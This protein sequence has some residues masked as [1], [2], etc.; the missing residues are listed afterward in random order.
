MKASELLT[1]D[2][3]SELRKLAAGNLEGPWQVPT[4]L[5]RRALA[6]GARTVEVS[7]SRGRVVIH[8]DGRPLS[9]ER[10]HH[11]AVLLDETQPS[12]VRHEA[13]LALEA[14]PELLSIAAA[15]ARRVVVHS[16]DAGTTVTLL[17]ARIDR[18]A[19][20]RW[21]RSCARFAPARVVVDGE[22]VRPGFEGAWAE[23]SLDA[24][25]DGRLAVT[26]DEGAHLWLLGAGIVSSH[27]TL[28]DTPAFEA[29]IELPRG[30]PSA[31]REAIQPHLG[32]LVD[33]AVR[34][35]LEIAG[36]SSLDPRKQRS[37]RAR[38][39]VAARRGWL[40]DEIFETPLLPAMDA[41]GV[42]HRLRL[43]Q[44]AARRTV[45]CLDTGDD[46]ADFLL[47]REPV[48]QVDAEERGRLA[49]LLSARFQ[50]VV[51][52]RGRLGLAAA[53]RRAALRLRDLAGGLAARLRHPRA[54]RVLPEGRLSAD[55]RAFLAALRRTLAPGAARVEIGAGSGPPRRSRDTWILS[56]DH[57]DVRR[58]VRLVA[59]DPSFAYLAAL[60]LCEDAVPL[61][62]ARD[63]WRDTFMQGSR[64]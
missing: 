10:R 24:P 47:P 57:A 17:G 55:E 22:L 43:S 46:P 31:L 18:E 8:D 50:P 3:D 54:G 1:I 39:F 21:L 48:V 53:L 64:P 15:H 41:Q 45:P 5:V 34:L 42:R 44:L 9:S 29:A 27:L 16:D 62:A 37:V 14:E 12:G 51:R 63:R 26:D 38:L 20:R 25:L 35:L 32:V 4:E 7:L 59:R 23:R 36:R 33:G 52:R 13:L 28:P 61:P 56:R 30:A 11:L 58:A 19:A 6:A 49:Q 2:T 60:A 40:R